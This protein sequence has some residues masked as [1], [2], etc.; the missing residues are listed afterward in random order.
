MK[1]E[2]VINIPLSEYNRLL[3]VDQENRQL[4][5]CVSEL[6]AKL[7]RSEMWTLVFALISLVYSILEVIRYFKM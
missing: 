2:H 1:K 5:F 7:L 3:N 6:R 4:N